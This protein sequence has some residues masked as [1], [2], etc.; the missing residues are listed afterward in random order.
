MQERNTSNSAATSNLIMISFVPD[1]IV[2]S[3]LGDGVFIMFSS[4]STMLHSGFF[5]TLYQTLAPY[6][7][8]SKETWNQLSRWLPGHKNT[9]KFFLKWY[10]Y[11][12]QELCCWITFT[13]CFRNYE[14]FFEKHNL[15]FPLGIN[16]LHYDAHATHN[17]LSEETCCINAKKIIIIIH[18]FLW[19]ILEFIC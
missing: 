2:Y 9:A 16:F 6:S 13:H 1:D 15:L 5:I 11:F 4:S 14:N 8:L 3:H 18:N 7:G 10:L 17:I 12:S 19:Y